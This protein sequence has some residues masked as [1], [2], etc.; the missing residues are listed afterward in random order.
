[1]RDF[2]RKIRD[3][4]FF[5]VRCLFP[6]N[7]YIGFLGVTPLSEERFRAVKLYLKGRVLDL[8]CGDNRLMREYCLGGGEGVGADLATNPQADV[9]LTAGEP[10]PFAD[11]S[12]D[13]IVM[14]ASLNHIPDRERVLRECYRCLVPGG[15]IVLTVLGSVVGTVGHWLWGCLGSDADLKHRR[16][17]EG[18]LK[19]MSQAEVYRML[20]QAGFKNIQ[21]HV[22]TMGLNNLYVAERSL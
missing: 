1:M 19:G 2:S 8:G 20:A 13:I 17:A 5:P 15:H 21:H 7:E 10:L 18:E 11:R 12:F 14:L 3:L 4:F 16:M 6:N 9:F 22:F